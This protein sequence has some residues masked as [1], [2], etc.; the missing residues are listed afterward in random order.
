MIIGY[1]DPWGCCYAK[2]TVPESP[3]RMINVGSERGE[4]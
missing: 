1:L 4:H 2:A 3:L